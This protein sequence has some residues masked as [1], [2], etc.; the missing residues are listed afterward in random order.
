MKILLQARIFMNDPG[1]SGSRFIFMKRRVASVKN[2]RDPGRPMVILPL[3]GLFLLVLFSCSGNNVGRIWDPNRGKG[4]GGG[5]TTVE[6]AVAA[7]REGDLSLSG[8]A[9]VGVVAPLGP[10]WHVTTPAAVFFSEAVNPGSVY[11]AALKVERVY[12]REK[13]PTGGTGGNPLP[14]TKVKS[15]VD[16]LGQGR[17]VILRPQAPLLPNVTYEIVMDSGVRDLDG[18]LA[19]GAGTL[20]S[21]TPSAAPT[22]KAKV[23]AVFPPPDS[24]DFSR[25]GKVFAVLDGPATASTV[26][27]SSF[28]ARKESGKTT[29]AGAV[30]FPLKGLTGT[31]TRVLL[32]TPSAPF[33]ASTEFG[34]VLKD[35]IEVAGQA[36]DPGK[37]DPYSKFTTMA[38]KMPAAV[39]IGNPVSGFPDAVNITNV[40][41]LRIDV[42]LPAETAAGDKV[43]A[44]VYG[45]DPR[46]KGKGD[47]RYIEKSATA[48]GGVQT[49]AV[50]FSGALG[51]EAAPLLEE[52]SL[53]LAAR[54]LRGGKPSG[55]MVKTGV[56]QDLVRPEVLSF[57]PPHGADAKTTFVTNLQLASL[58]GKASE[59][60]GRAELNSSGGNDLF[61]SNDEG[62]F[63]LK[64]LDLGRNAAGVSFTLNVTDE[65]GNLNQ[66]A[67]SGTIFQRGVLTGDVSSSGALTVEAW[68]LET[69][70]PI[71]GATVLIEP[72]APAKPPSG[73][74]TAVTGA[75]GRAVFQGL[76]GTRYTVT[77]VSSGHHLASVVDTRASFVSL[78]LE[79]TAGGAASFSGK[80]LPSPGTGKIAWV[81]CNA[82]ADKDEDGLVA[83]SSGDPGTIPASPMLPR[84]PVVVTACVGTFPATANPTLSAFG[85]PQAVVTGTATALSP[86]FMNVE[87]GG[88]LEP[89][90]LT[91]PPLAINYAAGYSKD[92][93]GKGLST[94]S[95]VSGFPRVSVNAALGGV[96]GSVLFGAGFTSGN[97]NNLAVNGQYSST[98]TAFSGLTPLLWSSLEARDTEGNRARHRE[99]FLDYTLGSLVG[100]PFPFPS[101]PAVTVPATSSGPP[102]VQWEDHLD[103]TGG[104]TA[105][106]LVKVQ[107]GNGRKWTLWVPDRD[108]TGMDTLQ[109]PDLSASSV[110]GL[111]RPSTWTIYVE[112]WFSV[113]VGG[114]SEDLALEDLFRLH[115]TFARGKAG[116]CSVQ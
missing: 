37:N 12:L 30:S 86:P 63:F 74:L 60:L 71:Q 64:P 68:D 49:L 82:L 33:E 4:G 50:D 100:L 89:S 32:F 115:I 77:I 52:G 14:S 15:R 27:S 28:F 62:F 43:E 20:G 83:T 18:K 110:T 105:V 80:V 42:D 54:I 106:H 16:I 97:V 57:G 99:L 13:K 1:K 107:D 34:V 35:T 113:I 53:T 91:L 39:K 48:A 59:K 104:Y 41:T 67:V 25:E 23:V 85:T 9:S 79:S 61:A 44:R 55:W 75:D 112:G 76:S 88:K 114:G 31:D 65:A 47:L 7:P 5:G 78:P 11:D 2:R 66:A 17:V 22:A 51:N 98:I 72:G 56:L 81:G 6:S 38:W 58:F 24:K 3:G 36:L 90:L 109:L 10:G 87:P 19:R 111:A 46:T 92:L 40:S 8:Q 102:Q 116:T 26:T 45:G 108:G 73:R 94:S 96:P 21:F 69:F 70:D 93:T 29:V 84:R 95:L 101:I 103:P